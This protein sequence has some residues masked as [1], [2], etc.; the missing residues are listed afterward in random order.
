MF[1]DC[2]TQMDCGPT[3]ACYHYFIKYFPSQNEQ[4]DFDK[5]INLDRISE[6]GLGF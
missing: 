1:I 4:N 5:K 6:S 2:E 3:S